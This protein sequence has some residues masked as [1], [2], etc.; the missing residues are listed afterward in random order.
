MRRRRLSV[1]EATLLIWAITIGVGL[2][3]LISL[4][5]PP[6]LLA[7]IAILSIGILFWISAQIVRQFF[8]RQVPDGH[9]GIVVAGRRKELV[10]LDKINRDVFVW[11]IIE[12]FETCNLNQPALELSLNCET[13]DRLNLIV[14][15]RLEWQIEYDG[16]L[17]VLEMRVKPE[18]VLKALTAA[19][20]RA[21]IGVRT[22]EEAKKELHKIVRRICYLTDLAIPAGSALVDDRTSDQRYNGVVEGAHH[23]HLQ[24]SSLRILD[25][26]LPPEVQ[27][28]A[29]RLKKTELDHQIL[30]KKVDVNTERY[31]TLDRFITDSKWL[32]G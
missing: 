2:L 22:Y 10:S 15:I 1:T 14:Q 24:V 28:V 20:L 26:R 19:A 32:H 31:R 25:M 9:A 21:E 3:V 11:P 12:K 7:L 13:K 17:R 18:E 27:E 6:L 5:F 29:A 23:Y 16:T 4:F 8:F 30:R